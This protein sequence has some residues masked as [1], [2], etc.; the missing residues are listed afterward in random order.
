MTPKDDN[1][2]QQQQQPAGDPDE[3]D[4]KRGKDT[5]FSEKEIKSVVELFENLPLPIKTMLASFVEEDEDNSTA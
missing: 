3:D 1:L 5:D 2:N 4:E